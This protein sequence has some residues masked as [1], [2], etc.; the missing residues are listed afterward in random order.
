[1]DTTKPGIDV[2]DFGKCRS[3]STDSCGS[4]TWKFS[5]STWDDESGIICVV[6]M[7]V[8]V[9]IVVIH[10]WCCYNY[11]CRCYTFLVVFIAVVVVV[12]IIID[13]CCCLKY[14]LLNYIVAKL[15]TVMFVAPNSNFQ[16]FILLNIWFLQLKYLFIPY[17]YTYKPININ[18]VK[19]KSNQN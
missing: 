19:F 1:M 8:V 5:A 11:C 10:C 4:E 3:A 9:V 17:G 2:H 15:G 7:V 16:Y 18:Q 14:T 13:C 12:I 6:I